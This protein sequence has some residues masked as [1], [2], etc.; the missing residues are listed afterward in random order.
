MNHHPSNE[1]LL[2][3]AS[4]LLTDSLGLIVACHIDMCESCCKTYKQY[5][6]LAAEMVVESSGE[7][8]S[9]E[10]FDRMM[11]SLDQVRDVEADPATVPGLPKP[12]WRLVPQGL[13]QL[14]WKGMF[15]S[16]QT[17]DVETGD[18]RYVG[19]F[20]KILAGSKLPQHSH[21]GNE[22]TLVLKGSFSDEMGRYNEGDFIVANE[23]TEHQPVAGMEEDCICFAV[24]DA[25]IRFSGLQGLILNPFMAK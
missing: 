21:R 24:L 25:P 18:P 6:S 23:T 10:L 4:G 5:E 22:I 11:A 7:Q 15:K 9:P 12:L 3:H 16:V 20:Y 13:D 19:R 2:K 1:V 14:N 17:F 8:V